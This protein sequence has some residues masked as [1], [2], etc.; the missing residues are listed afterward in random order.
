MEIP[1]NTKRKFLSAEWQNLIMAN[2]EVDPSIMIMGT[3]ARTGIKG[4]LIGN[5]AEKLLDIVD[6]DLLTVN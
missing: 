4:K 6:A 5:T 1:K 3:L 2:Y